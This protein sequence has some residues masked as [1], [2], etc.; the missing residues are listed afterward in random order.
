[1]WSDQV[2][3]EPVR[4]CTAINILAGTLL[5]SILINIV[6]ASVMGSSVNQ[7]EQNEIE[8]IAEPKV[9][10]ARIIKKSNTG[11]VFDNSHSQGEECTCP[12]TAWQ[13][14]EILVL[15]CI[16]TFLLHCGL[17]AGWRMRQL[18]AQWQGAREERLKRQIIKQHR[19]EEE[20]RD[21]RAEALQCAR[22]IQAEQ[23][24]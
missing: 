17:K 2:M 18:C 22:G 3:V 23:E 11:V 19:L 20:M 10:Q 1:M 21:Q 9:E 12:G 14:L 4:R 15:A 24:L 8:D 5:V 13:L 16:L 7:C 6:L